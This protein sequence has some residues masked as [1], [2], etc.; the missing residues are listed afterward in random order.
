MVQQ[1]NNMRKEFKL[2]DEQLDKVLDA[3]KP[4]KLI[5]LQTGMPRSPQENANSAWKAL[6]EEMG[7]QFMTV[8]PV[9]SKDDHYFTAEVIGMRMICPSC[10]FYFTAPWQEAE[11]E[12]IPT[13]EICPNCEVNLL[14]GEVV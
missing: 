3:S 6:G 13:L 7:F 1:V 12:E 2:T 5:A 11:T 8:Q 9:P 14:D 4:V 10:H